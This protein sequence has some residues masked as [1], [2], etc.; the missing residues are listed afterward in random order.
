[1]SDQMFIDYIHQKFIDRTQPP[2]KIFLDQYLI[3]A[4]LNYNAINS[5][6]RCLTVPHTK[7]SKKKKFTETNF[8]KDFFRENDLRFFDENDFRFSKILSCTVTSSCGKTISTSTKYM[9]LL[10]D[11]WKSMDINDVLDNTSFNIKRSNEKGR[12][13]YNWHQC[14]NISVQSREA[15]CTLKEIMFMIYHNKYNLDMTIVL[16]NQK[17]IDIKMNY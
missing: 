16:K 4:H 5:R 3:D 15:K 2:K 17:E 11:I 8:F 7:K 12:R 6:K 13:G 10:I 9:S 1:M 14:L